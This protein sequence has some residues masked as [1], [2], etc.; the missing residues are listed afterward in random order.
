ME[1]S[2]SSEIFKRLIILCGIIRTQKTIML[3][4]N[5]FVIGGMWW[6]SWVRHYATSWKVAGSI[7]ILY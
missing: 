6:H 1:T 3:D 5:T 4:L 2:H 7:G